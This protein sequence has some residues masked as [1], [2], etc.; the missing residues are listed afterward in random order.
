MSHLHAQQLH[1]THNSTTVYLT[2]IVELTCTF[3]AVASAPAAS[4]SLMIF[5][6]P[7]SAACMSGVSPCKYIVVM[8]Q[9]AYTQTV[10]F[11]CKCVLNMRNGQ[12]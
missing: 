2:S 1:S 8:L 5:K 3:V 9:N 6:L 7:L 4:S 11:M 12:K 10:A